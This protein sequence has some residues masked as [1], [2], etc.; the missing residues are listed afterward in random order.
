MGRKKDAPKEVQAPES[1]K[2]REERAKQKMDEELD[3]KSTP[4]Q[5]I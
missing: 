4:E 2:A 5:N 1:R 3:E